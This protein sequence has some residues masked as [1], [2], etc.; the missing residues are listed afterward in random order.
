MHPSTHYQLAHAHT[1]DL[2]QRAARQRTARAAIQ[3]R[4]AQP[5]HR[6]RLVPGHAVTVLARVLALAGGH[7]LSPTR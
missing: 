1:A 5:R 4:R 6:A 3:G 2:H 7:R